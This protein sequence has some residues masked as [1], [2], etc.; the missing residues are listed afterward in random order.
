MWTIYLCS[1]I[2]N[3]GHEKQAEKSNSWNVLTTTTMMMMMITII[4][5]LIHVIVRK[6]VVLCIIVLLY[7]L[8]FCSIWIFRVKQIFP[9]FVETDD[10]K[11]LR[12]FMGCLHSSSLIMPLLRMEII[13]ELNYESW[14]QTSFII[15][16]WN[17][18]CR[19]HLA[20]STISLFTFS[21]FFSLRKNPTYHIFLRQTGGFLILPPIYTW[22][23]YKHWHL[24]SLGFFLLGF[25]FLSIW[26]KLACLFLFISWQ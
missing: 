20:G 14:L 8:M 26:Q 5:T 1:L 24:F 19:F 7:H 11:V 18:S 22:V 17:F 21:L 15:Q 13:N 9:A 6:M 12:C 23:A 4:S 10:I 2:L 25:I 3:N 16:G